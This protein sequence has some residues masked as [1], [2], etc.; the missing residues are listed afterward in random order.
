[1]V[2]NSS[3]EKYKVQLH[4]KIQFWLKITL[5]SLWTHDSIWFPPPPTDFLKQ[6]RP[7]KEINMLEQMKEGKA[8]LLL[9]I[10]TFC[11]LSTDLLTLTK[12][13]PYCNKCTAHAHVCIPNTSWDMIKFILASNQSILN[14]FWSML[15]MFVCGKLLI[16]WWIWGWKALAFKTFCSVFMFV[17]CVFYF[18]DPNSPPEEKCYQVLMDL[19]DMN[20]CVLN[21]K[22]PSALDQS[23]RK[24]LN[25]KSVRIHFSLVITLNNQLSIIL[26]VQFLN[27]QSKSYWTLI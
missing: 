13:N 22:D 3:W 21:V 2:K 20:L 6:S 7:M 4:L 25:G 16:S 17:Q 26:K 12:T 8:F 15:C 19:A 23:I 1:M 5:I 10:N 9:F 24:T 11:L 18:K 14:G 27:R